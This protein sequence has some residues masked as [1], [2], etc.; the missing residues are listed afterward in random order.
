[1][2]STTCIVSY[3][4]LA[5]LIVC[6]YKCPDTSRAKLQLLLCTC[7]YI[8]SSRVAAASFQAAAN[9]PPRISAASSPSSLAIS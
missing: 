6:M 8:Y 3:A 9:T 2:D 4:E 5:L 7:C 1:M